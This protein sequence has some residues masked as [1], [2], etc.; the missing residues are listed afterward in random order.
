MGKEPN[1]H[2]Q[3]YSWRRSWRRRWWWWCRTLRTH[4]G[5]KK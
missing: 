3:R 1:L 4:T 5:H 2:M